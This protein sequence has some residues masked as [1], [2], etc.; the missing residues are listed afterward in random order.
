MTFI[1]Q[2]EDTVV[3]LSA[4]FTAQCGMEYLLLLP[5]VFYVGF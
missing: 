5:F 2:K 4:E 1:L 3:L